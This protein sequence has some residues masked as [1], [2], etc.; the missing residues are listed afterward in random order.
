MKRELVFLFVLMSFASGFCEKYSLSV[1]DAVN[2][3]KKNNVSIARNQITLDAS[4]RSKNHSWNSVSPTGSLGVS[5]SIPLDALTGGD[6]NSNYTASI[7]VSASLSLSLSANLYTSMNK[8]KLD[9][10]QQ[11]VSFNDAVRSIEMSVRQSYYGLLYELENIRLQQENLNIAKIQY[12]NNFA[13]YNSGR[14]S[15]LDAL[16]AEVN[17]KS[18]IPTVEN[19]VTV[20]KNDLA[21]FKQ[22]L[23]LM[24]EDE[25]TLTGSLDD[26]LILDEIKIDEKNIRSST[27][28]ALENRLAIA[29]NSLLEKRFSAFAPSL[30]ASFS[31]RDQNW[32]VGWS[33]YVN[34]QGKTVTKEDAKKSSSL[35]LSASIPLDGVLP[36][37]NKNDGVDSAKDTVADLEL[38]L[39]N[40]RKDLK[41]SVDSSLRS[42]AQSQEAIKYKQANVVLAQKTYEMTEAAYNHGTKDLMTLQNA[43]TTLLNAQVSLKN[44]VYTLAKAILSLEN[45]IGVPF[46]ELGRK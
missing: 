7:G 22:V 3:A 36:W 41:R 37:S 15:E 33:D 20:Y 12:E 16:S 1:D 14:L 46:G 5:S 2:L 4:L 25:I 40:S 31:W 27:L 42:I 24:L 35:T 30:S 21:S 10:E 44:E 38:Q 28:T 11:K 26:V 45:T 43:N 34:S 17:Y 8:A 23:G 6:Q 9:Y 39:D 19:A 32:Y 18:K 29:K 13:K